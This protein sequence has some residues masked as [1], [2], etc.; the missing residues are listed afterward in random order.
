MLLLND[1]I[2]MYTNPK[3]WYELHEAEHIKEKINTEL[4]INNGIGYIKNKLI[5][6]PIA[7]FAIFLGKNINL[8][9]QYSAIVGIHPIYR[10]HTFKHD[11]CKCRV[12]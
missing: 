10:L 5:S 8:N 1:Y 12:G 11:K 6:I 4:I 2:Q 9:K 3:H 7:K